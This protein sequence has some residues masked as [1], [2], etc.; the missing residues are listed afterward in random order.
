MNM[1]RRRP[2]VSRGKV[3]ALL[4]MLGLVVTTACSAPEQPSETA[5]EETITVVDDAGRTV[6]FD[7]PI[8]TAV[9][10]NRYNSELIRAMGDI[11]KVI[12][13][14]SNTA[15]DRVY[16][17]QFDPDNV[18]GKGQSE[19]NVE[20]IIELDP[21]VLILPRNGNVDE[22]AAALE[23]VGIKVLTVTGWDNGDFA[24]Q[25][26]IL[27]SAFGNE[28]GAEKVTEFFEST[29]ADIADR[30]GGI[31]PKKTVYWEYGD[32]FTTA[33][34]GT[35][36]DGWHQMIVA[37]GGVNMFG[38][39]TLEGNTVDPEEILAADPD[40]VLKTTSGGALK[41][42]GV[43]TPP[44][45]GEFASIG[46]EMVTRPGWPELTAVREGNVHMITGFAG[47]GLGKIVG[48]AYLATWLYPEEMAGFDPD[49]VFSRW[50]E[51]QGMDMP[52][53]HVFTVPSAR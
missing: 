47:G 25:L 36:N 40:L 33:I 15:Q 14:D 18:I 11:D 52:E 50:L 16:W 21:E 44:A 45:D 49:A 17:S 8:E 3:V 38:D 29:K 28:S 46:Q 4:T 31:E 48:S 30:V 7:G 9:V 35:S 20:K 53:G 27:G 23:P 24:S 12:S 43:Y 13:V 22:Y 6:E 10:A 42:T 41:N 32:P 2:R 39:P 5:A 26:E 51:L 19:L 34:P 37:A 1:N